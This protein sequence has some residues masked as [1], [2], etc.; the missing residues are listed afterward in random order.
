MSNLVRKVQIAAQQQRLPQARPM[1]PAALDPSGYDI[2]KMWW[3]GHVPE[4]ERRGYYAHEDDQLF[5]TAT[6]EMEPQGHRPQLPVW[7]TGNCPPWNCPSYWTKPLDLSF[8]VCCVPTYEDDYFVGSLEA[9]QMEMLVINSISY[10]VVTG[11]SQYEVFEVTMLSS[12]RRKMQIEDMII[13]PTAADPARR[14]AFAGD[15][16]PLPM[17]WKV[18]R[19]DRVVFNV[20]ARGLVGLDGV[21]SQNPGDPLIPNMDFRLSVQG[22]RVPLRRDVDGGP[23][24]IDLGPME[25][26]GLYE[27]TYLEGR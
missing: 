7:L 27:D 8:P 6:N 2:D 25:N 1:R 15:V 11:L 12:L 26:A 22:W 10:E 3:R 19:N 9:E 21:S 18:D 13:D 14:Y 16:L 23:R 20:K 5:P 24:P 17:W 4:P